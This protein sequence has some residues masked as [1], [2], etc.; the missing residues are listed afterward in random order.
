MLVVDVLCDTCGVYCERIAVVGRVQR[1][2][3]RAYVQSLAERLGISGMVWNYPTAGVGI[4]ACH[5][6]AGVLFGDFMH[7]LFGGPGEVW[8]LICFSAEMAPGSGFQVLLT[9]PEQ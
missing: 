4:I 3:Y 8:T 1:V 2:G 7:G 9:A 5:E 6:N